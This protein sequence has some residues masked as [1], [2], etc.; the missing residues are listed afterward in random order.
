M[1][2]L[3]ACQNKKASQN[4]NLGDKG[5]ELVDNVD[6]EFDADDTVVFDT[7]ENEKVDEMGKNEVDEK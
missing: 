7:E 4:A 3:G 1:V 5:E 6:D 2:I